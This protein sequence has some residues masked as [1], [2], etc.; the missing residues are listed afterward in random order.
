MLFPGKYPVKFIVLLFMPGV[1]P[2]IADHFKLSF[3]DVLDQP[4]NKFHSGNRFGDKSIVFMPVIV[5]RNGIAIIRVN[6]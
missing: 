4:G 3:G 1:K 5:K 6:A 2:I